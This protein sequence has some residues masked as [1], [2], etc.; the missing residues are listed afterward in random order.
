MEYYLLDNGTIV[1]EE[2]RL[3]KKIGVGEV[4]VCILDCGKFGKIWKRFKI[5]ESSKNKINLERR[6]TNGKRDL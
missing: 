2:G 5:V 3:V 1:K 4:D 6:K